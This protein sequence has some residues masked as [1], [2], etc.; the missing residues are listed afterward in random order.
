[1]MT[2]DLNDTFFIVLLHC[3]SA[4]AQP[5]NAE[6][7]L[8]DKDRT[9]ADSQFSVLNYSF[10]SATLGQGGGQMLTSLDLRFRT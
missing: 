1:M 2:F 4:M 3:N 9:R 5:Q 7:A 8:R 6:T 10:N